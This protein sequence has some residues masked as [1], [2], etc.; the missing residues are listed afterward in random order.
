METERDTE[1]FTHQ[2][3]MDLYRHSDIP[4]RGKIDARLARQ[5]NDEGFDKAG[6][7]LLDLN[8]HLDDAKVSLANWKSVLCSHR[9]SEES[10]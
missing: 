4:L 7:I 10:I 3:A 1:T 8:L 6:L 9:R 5:M 2:L